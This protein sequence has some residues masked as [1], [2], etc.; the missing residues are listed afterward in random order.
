MSHERLQDASWRSKHKKRR[1]SDPI[2]HPV[3][4]GLL[5]LLVFSYFLDEKTFILLQNFNFVLVLFACLFVYF[6]C[7]PKVRN[8]YFQ[9]IIC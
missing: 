8:Y 2:N 7:H 1:P 6:R 9:Y 3:S 5:L 4:I